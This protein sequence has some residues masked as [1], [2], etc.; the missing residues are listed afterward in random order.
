MQSHIL[1]VVESAKSVCAVGVV[2]SGLPPLIATGSLAVR[3]TVY[4]TAI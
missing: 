4:T 2:T 1:A 3:T